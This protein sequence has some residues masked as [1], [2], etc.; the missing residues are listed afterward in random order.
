MKLFSDLHFFYDG[1]YNS[2]I[3]NVVRKEEW[4]K[5][6][7]DTT[8]KKPHG[9]WWKI[10]KIVCGSIFLLYLL[11]RYVLFSFCCCCQH[12]VFV[13]WCIL[14]CETLTSS[15]LLFF[16]KSKQK[17]VT[18]WQNY[19]FFLNANFVWKYIVWNVDKEERKQTIVSR[20]RKK[21][22]TKSVK[23]NECPFFSINYI[24]YWHNSIKFNH[25]I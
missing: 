2:W 25:W 19:T 18:K 12:L 21:E 20:Q 7:R 22:E 8:Q 3:Q 13:I 6:W 5:K 17:Y 15:Q 14:S 9:I 24:F 23:N 16:L 11:F 4:E 1:I 10:N